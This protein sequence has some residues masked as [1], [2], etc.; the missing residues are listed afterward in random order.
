M[1]TLLWAEGGRPKACHSANPSSVLSTC[2]SPLQNLSRKPSCECSLSFQELDT[3]RRAFLTWEAA[4]TG[5]D[6]PAEGR[7]ARDGGGNASCLTGPPA[8][9]ELTRPRCHREPRRA[10]S[11]QLGQSCTCHVAPTCR[12]WAPSCRGVAHSAVCA[13]LTAAGPGWTPRSP[14]SHGSREASQTGLDVG[15]G[16]PGDASGRRS[17]VR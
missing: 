17:A 16:G 4:L 9:E 1:K 13:L 5:Q 12:M 8:E 2:S 7:G 11:R 15:K 3:G 14:P 10:A 6:G